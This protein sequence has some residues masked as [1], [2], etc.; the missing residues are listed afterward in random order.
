MVAF[1]FLYL[2]LLIGTTFGL[3]VYPRSQTY[4]VVDIA[5]REPGSSQSG[6][7]VSSFFSGEFMGVHA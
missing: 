6:G 4:D 2:G 1:R 3:P 5:S 7:H